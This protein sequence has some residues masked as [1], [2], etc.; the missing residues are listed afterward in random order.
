MRRENQIEI[1]LY[2][3]QSFEG[4]QW[5]GFGHRRRGGRQ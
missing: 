3:L 1:E 2:A 4:K 5:L